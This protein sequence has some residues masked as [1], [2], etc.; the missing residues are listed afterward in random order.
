MDS[1]L[2][3]VL[4]DFKDGRITKSE[5]IGGLAHVI[6]AIDKGNYGEAINWFEQGRRLIRAT[7]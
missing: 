1:F 7:R 3:Y 4:E 5:A 6:A 2:G